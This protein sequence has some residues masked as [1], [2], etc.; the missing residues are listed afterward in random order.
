M[1]K[2]KEPPLKCSVCK[3]PDP[4]GTRKGW[5]TIIR[6][7]GH[8]ENTKSLTYCPKCYKEQYGDRELPTIA[9]HDGGTTVH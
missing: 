3:K 5:H 7:Q 4:K 9:V 8:A 2:T 6:F 1:K